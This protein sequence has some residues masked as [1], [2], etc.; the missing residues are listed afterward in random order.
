MKKYL[1]IIAC[2]VALALLTACSNSNVKGIDALPIGVLNPTGDSLSISIGNEYIRSTK[3]H[4]SSIHLSEGNYEVKVKGTELTGLVPVNVEVTS[5]DESQSSYFSNDMVFINPNPKHN[6]V[7]IN[8]V[9]FYEDAGEAEVAEKFIG[10]G[11]IRLNQTSRNVRLEHQKL[12]ETIEGY[13]SLPY[14]YKLYYLPGD[15]VNKSDEE[16][17]TYCYENGLED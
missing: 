11:V 1:S 3:Y 14:V 2:T 4:G 5:G 6:Y 15:L 17:L 16:I 13:G 7:A 8:C 12:P 9:G 10:E